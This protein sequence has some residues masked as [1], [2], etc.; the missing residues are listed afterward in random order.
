MTV[1]VRTNGERRLG[2]APTRLAC[3]G[4]SS[5]NR[6]DQRDDRP[7]VSAEELCPCTGRVS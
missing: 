2:G 4:L 7:R 5:M 6:A 1:R 3:H